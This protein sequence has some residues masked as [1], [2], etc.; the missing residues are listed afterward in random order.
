MSSNT[1]AA[2]TSS[3]AADLDGDGFS[4]LVVGTPFGRRQS[5]PAADLRGG[6]PGRSRKG[7]TSA[8]GT[9]WSSPRPPCWLGVERAA[10][11]GRRASR[12]PGPPTPPSGN[13]YRTPAP[14]PTTVLTPGERHA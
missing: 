14:V 6:S 10:G 7:P 8:G 13:R 11:P 2:R 9:A 12:C 5:L 1:L 4:D 3:S